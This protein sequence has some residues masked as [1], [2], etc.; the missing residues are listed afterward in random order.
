MSNLKD[1]LGQTYNRLTVLEHVGSNKHKKALWRCLCSCGKEA[2]VIGSALLNGSTTSCGCYNLE[3]LS[4]REPMYKGKTNPH[5]LK[6]GMSKDAKNLPPIYR[7][8]QG[9]KTRCT[10]TKIPNAKYYSGRG[11]SYDPSW[12]SF[13]TFYQDMGDKPEGLSLDR[14]N[15]DKGYSKENCRWA[16][17]GA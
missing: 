14:I 5:T 16:T 15:N 2:I 17:P 7:V 9:M 6:H 12:E 4:E 10:N 11:I 8:W 13:Q 1:L 3:L